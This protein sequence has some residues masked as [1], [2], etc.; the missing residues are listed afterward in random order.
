MMDAVKN[1]FAAL[2]RREQIL[3]GVAGILLFICALVFGAIRPLWLGSFAAKQSYQQQAYA[4][5]ELDAR[6]AMLQS[7]PDTSLEAAPDKGG[8]LI[9][10]LTT[11]AAARSITLSANNPSAD[12]G[13]SITIDNINPNSFFTWAIALEKRG[14]ML[15]GLSMQP[16]AAQ[17][18]TSGLVSVRADFVRFG[19]D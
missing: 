7:P 1:W 3:V 15:A 14:V 13:A 6:Y 12:G 10:L 16:I 2:S 4:A 18:G 19:N 17:S 5:A 11:D 8:S 9:Q